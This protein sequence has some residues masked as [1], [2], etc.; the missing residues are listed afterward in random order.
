MSSSPLVEPETATTPIPLPADF[1]VTW[2]EPEDAQYLWLRLL[3]I[4]LRLMH[5]HGVVGTAL[6]MIVLYPRARS[7]SELPEREAEG[8]VQGSGARGVGWVRTCRTKRKQGE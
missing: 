8:G 1:S 5:I 4:E 2:A 7:R 6:T 3:S